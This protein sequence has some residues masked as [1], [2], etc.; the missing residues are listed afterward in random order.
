MR[1]IPILMALLI[2][3]GCIGEPT[4]AAVAP[5]QHP[6]TTTTST[7]STTTTEPTTT[8]TTTTTISLCG[9]GLLDP[10]EECDT[11]NLCPH[12]DGVC[13]QTAEDNKIVY[14]LQDAACNHDTE[15]F[16]Q[17]RAFNLG[18]CR[19]CY[20]PKHKDMCTCTQP[21]ALR[22]T[23]TTTTLSE[24]HYECS[25]GLCVRT[26]GPGDDECLRNIQCYHFTCENGDC[27]MV[28][29]PGNSTCTNNF[30]CIT[31]WEE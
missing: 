9:N 5:Q 24:G 2:A 7:T 28:K 8:T 27:V 25:N 30:N 17:G 6:T 16:T 3:S 22:G 18:G 15:Y 19:A 20:G 11:G 13:A 14:C 31:Y 23:T 4:G 29:E 21:N 12:A 1:R 26:Q 10:G